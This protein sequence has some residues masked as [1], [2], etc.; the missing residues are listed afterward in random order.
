MHVRLICALLLLSL[1]SVAPVTAQDRI[2]SLHQFSSALEELSNRVRP[3]VVQIFTT[4]YMPVQE[5]DS[6]D[7]SSPYSRQRAT[8]SG[9]ILSA[10]GYILTNAHVVLSARRIQVRL[11]AMPGETRKFH[12]I[13]KPEGASLDAKL[14]GLDR[15]TDLAVVKVDAKSL[16]F[17]ELGN[18]DELKQGQFVMA[19]GNPRGLEGS[20]S[21]GVVSST[22]RQIRPDDVMIY[23]QTDAAI[24]PGNSGGPLV[25]DA[26][27]VMGINTFILTQSGGSE[28]IGFAVPSNIAQ[29]VYRQI[30]REGHVHRGQVGL[31][32]QTITPALAVGLKLPQDWGVIVA[33]VTPD[34]PADEAGL[35]VGDL[36]QTLDDKPME[37]ARQFDVDLYQRALNDVVK[38]GVLR[39]GKHLLFNVTVTERVDDPLRFADLVNPEDNLVPKLGILG[40]T[41]DHKL[42]QMLPDLRKP[43]GV[44]VAARATEG[45]A[46]GT[47]LE[48]GDVI[49]TVD[50]TP[51]HSVAALRQI[52]D[53]HKT[54]DTP[55][56]QI[57]RDGNLMYITP[58]LE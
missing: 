42:L 14:V 15:E 2:A 3:A 5:S 22:A 20:V 48:T 57:E 1:P 34:G 7:T 4:S 32:A 35:E 54:G 30:V 33:D 52:L 24:N 26:G 41:L 12:S 36:I 8:G 51:V 37:N 56:L 10:D 6:S 43:Y 44:V 39:N 29:A 13:V 18:S 55:V 25:D 19:F 40:I 16:P 53:G 38:V 28:G 47:R 11:S 9:V 21:I 23:L 49:Y 58:E 27:R 46:E 45:Q 31:D 50:A 17:L